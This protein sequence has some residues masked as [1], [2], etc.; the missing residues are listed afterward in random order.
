MKKGL[1]ITLSI[2]GAI[3]ILISTTLL[4][5]YLTH[6]KGQKRSDIAIT[7]TDNTII[8]NNTKNIEDCTAKECLYICA[9]K[10]KNMTSYYATIEGRVETSLGIDQSVSGRKYKKGNQSLYVSKSASSFLSMAK[11]IYIEDDLVMVRDAEDVENDVYKDTV[12]SFNMAGYLEEYGIDYR[13]LSNYE[14]NDES[15]TSAEFVSCENG[16]YKYRYTIDITKVDAYRVNMAK[17][18]DLPSLPTMV[19]CT[20]E[21]VM[22]SNFMPVTVSH[23]DEYVVDYVFFNVN[24]TASL[25]QT[26]VKI[27]DGT[28]EI[29]EQEFFKS[30]KA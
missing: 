23:F 24:C 10:L 21:V 3:I 26:F 15:I 20:F 18:G 28:I 27:N 29:P 4:V 17:M 1:V 19:S 13:E 16:E 14:L 2:I 9:G 22:D 8:D 5:L 12:E 25:T 11:Q 30:Q 7:P 6:D